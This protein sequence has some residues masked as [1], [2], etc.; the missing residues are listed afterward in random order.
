MDGMKVFDTLLVLIALV[1]LGIV[2]WWGAVQLPGETERMQ[3]DLQIAA[4]DELNRAG[5]TW[6]TVTMDG[7]HATITGTQAED[8]RVAEAYR[9][10]LTSSGNGGLVYGGVTRITTVVDAPAVVSPFTWSA[11][12]S[13]EGGLSLSGHV[14]SE[15]IRADLLARAATLVGGV[16]PPIDTMVIASGAPTGGWQTTAEFALMQLDALD[17]GRVSMR[18]TQLTVRGAAEDAAVRARIAS[19]VT[20]LG[21]P[22][23]GEVDLQGPSQWSARR[24]RNDL[25]LTG[26]VSSEAAKADIADL[27]GDVFEGRLMDEM[28]VMPDVA[29]GVLDGV[30]V[31]LPQFVG[32]Q[33]GEMAFDPQGD[34]WRFEGQAPG[35]TLSFLR[36]DLGLAGLELPVLVS[37]TPLAASLDDLTGLDFES[38]PQ[39]AC[40][41]AFAAVL[42]DGGVLFGDGTAEISRESGRVLDR[43]VSVAGTC[44]DRL[45][46]ELAGHTDSTGSRLANLQLSRARA[47]AVANFMV[48]AG[49]AEERLDVVGYGPDRPVGDNDTEE[50]R[51]ANRRLE[52]SVVERSE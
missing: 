4:Q 29:E 9:T 8:E 10:V 3:T 13:A 36:E 14:P 31:A 23:S 47:Q 28:T 24:F 17:A 43:I 1:G 22:F 6:A 18:D 12:K 44:D 7:Q 51:A 19:D 21:P 48:N 16:S 20:T 52:F 25:I 49:V 35:S 42:A 27:A 15:E 39:A 33:W 45:V 11:E 34:G 38:D 37:A 50:G 30:R 41:S 32:F 26:D 5:L 2:G 40:E 46:F